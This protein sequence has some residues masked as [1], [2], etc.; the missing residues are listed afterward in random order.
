MKYVVLDCETGGLDENRHSLLTAYFCVI[1]ERLQKIDDLSLKIKPNDGIYRIDTSALKVNK[2]DLVKHADG[3]VT[4]E[5]AAR[6]LT[7]FLSKHTKGGESPLT[8]VGHN[9]SFDE[10]F[11]KEQLLTQVKTGATPEELWDIYFGRDFVDTKGLASVL[12]LKGRIP[13][14]WSTSLKSMAGLLGTEYKNAHTAEGDVIS[15]I[16]LLRAML[17]YIN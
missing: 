9:L 3:A 10:K 5:V 2:I 16:N 7:I 1:D 15:T 8:P 14:D 13:E 11:I 12:K 6:Q 17:G 4:A